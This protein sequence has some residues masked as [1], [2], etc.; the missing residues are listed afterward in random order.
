MQT[1]TVK[2]FE[3][4]EGH[5]MPKYENTAYADSYADMLA[6]IN[7]EEYGS[8]VYSFD[9]TQDQQAEI[10]EYANS[11]GIFLLKRETKRLEASNLNQL[12]SIINQKDDPFLYCIS[13]GFRMED[14]LSDKQINNLLFL[15]RERYIFIDGN[16]KN[17]GYMC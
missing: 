5:P 16:S 15:W 3:Y 4:P 10:R 2:K 1:Q 7:A 14:H 6:I 13:L 8:C 9:M 11:Q 17:N 12:Y